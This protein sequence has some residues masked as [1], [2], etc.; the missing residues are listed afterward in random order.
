MHTPPPRTIH[1]TPTQ[2]Q[3]ERINFC[4]QK[5]KTTNSQNSLY[6]VDFT[7]KLPAKSP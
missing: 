1:E 7:P 2:A 3:E 4:L 6:F 5:S